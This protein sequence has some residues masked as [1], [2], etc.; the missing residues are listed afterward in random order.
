MIHVTGRDM[1]HPPFRAAYHPDDIKPLIVRRGGAFP[2]HLV[3]TSSLTSV[4]A[5]P[6]VR[7]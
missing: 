4:N 1:T 2:C 3:L 7:R 6:A 5:F